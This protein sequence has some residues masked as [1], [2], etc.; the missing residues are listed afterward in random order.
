[1]EVAPHHLF[2]SL[3]MFDPG[4]PRGKVN[5][6]LRP[7]SEVK[8]LW[9]RWDRIHAIASDHA[10][11]TGEEKA[12]DFN[13]APSGI[14]GV[15]TMVPLLVARC[16]E[17][18]IPLSSLMEKTSWGPSGILGISRAGFAV[19]ERAD[20]ALYPG[21]ARKIQAEDLHS[22]AGWTPFEGM[23]AVFPDLVVMG[24]RVAYRLGDFPPASPRW[25]PGRGYIGTGQM[26]N[27]ADTAQ[28]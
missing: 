12:L 18:K 21:D 13:A 14:P 9:S 6:P 26:E 20:F 19:G 22:K 3:G 5:P 17:R 11:H 7:E 10:P 4:D 23:D 1:M 25:I 27:G 16:R 15:E 28:P 2:L 24:G 8:Q